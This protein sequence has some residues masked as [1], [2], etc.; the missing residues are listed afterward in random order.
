[1]AIGIARESPLGADLAMLMARHR[2]AMHLE[3]PPES[4]HMMEADALVSPDVSFFVVRADG[5]P[6]AMGAFKLL[7]ATHAEIKSMH[8]LVEN[9][10]AGLSQ[11]L[12]A[13]L[14]SEAKAAGVA[15]V[16]LETGSQPGF[17]AAHRLYEKAG[18]TPCP[19]FADYAEDPLSVFMSRT[20]A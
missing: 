19:P 5:K 6:V 2:E 9:R 18:F 3:T 10:G 17:A 8:V 4:I 20:L 12:L 14:L 13:H 11:Q 15:R 16:S 1:M 7:D